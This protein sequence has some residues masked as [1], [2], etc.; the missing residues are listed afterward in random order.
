MRL[1][2]TSYI[3]PADIITNVRKLAGSVQDIELV[4]FEADDENN[5]PDKH[6]IR[7]LK[8]IASDNDMSY[9]VHLP[10][11]LK[12][13]ADK[14]AASIRKA[15]RVIRSTVELAPIG[16]IVHLENEN[17]NVGLDSERWLDNSVT[18]LEQLA[19]EI[20][21]PSIICVENL[22]NHSPS[23]LDLLTERA[24]VS[25]C[26]DIGHL[27]KQGL[28]PVPHLEQWLPRARIV[29]MHGI[30]TRDHTSLSSVDPQKLDPVVRLLDEGFRGVLTF[31]VF[32]EADFQDSLEAFGNSVQRVRAR[33]G[34]KE[35]GECSP[36]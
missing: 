26:A 14:S 24:P 11:D 16:F 27:W 29:H 4:L 28:D 18:S 1:G 21:D 10:L 5:L 8:R 17:Q 15:L 20:G 2:T 3:Y 33:D 32:S 13:A 34:N 23:L 7:E 31:E 30:R 6:V 22:E 19:R 25:C 36:G 9:T 35:P 12:L